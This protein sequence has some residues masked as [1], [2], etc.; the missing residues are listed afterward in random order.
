MVQ[1]I[2]RRLLNGWKERNRC[3]L[4]I[5]WKIYNSLFIIR[6]GVDYMNVFCFDYDVI[7]GGVYKK[8]IHNILDSANYVYF[9]FHED[10][11][12]DEQ[13]LQLRDT[14]NNAN[15]PMT[16]RDENK[17]VVGYEINI[18]IKQF[19]F[20]YISF[21]ELLNNLIYG[22]IFFFYEKEEIIAI[23]L[24]DFDEIYIKTNDKDMINVLL[25]VTEKYNG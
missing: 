14:C 13:V 3:Y 24:S 9:K 15:I 22:E 17:D 16:I 10:M 23:Q 25:D 7:S 6:K 1:F 18:F 8:I 19:F 2:E 21:Y 4:G 5:S 11:M 12:I 20:K